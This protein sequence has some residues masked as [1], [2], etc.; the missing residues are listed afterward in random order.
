MACYSR[1]GSL[2]SSEWL[3]CDI[4]ANVSVC[5]SEYDFC[6]SNG[7]CLTAKDVNFYVIEACTDPDWNEPCLNHCSSTE[8]GEQVAPEPSSTTLVDE[9]TIYEIDFNT[10][11]MVDLCD[12]WIGEFCCPTGFC[13]DE[14]AEKFTSTFS[15]VFRAP[16]ASSSTGTPVY[17]VATE[18]VYET[19]A[20]GATSPGAHSEASSKSSLNKVALGVGLG[21]ALPLGLLLAGLGFLMWRRSRHTEYRVP[22]STSADDQPESSRPPEMLSGPSQPWAQSADRNTASGSTPSLGEHRQ[23]TGTGEPEISIAVSTK[24]PWGSS[25]LGPNPNI[26]GSSLLPENETQG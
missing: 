23:K 12:P 20:P 24:L 18:T 25:S 1:S 5:C 13:L 3:P 6:L 8:D 4:D 14:N 7:L 9:L 26:P 11:L 21:A 22:V 15:N 2:L 10:G 17:S 19:A 16:T